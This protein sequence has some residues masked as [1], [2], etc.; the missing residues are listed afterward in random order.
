MHKQTYQFIMFIK[1]GLGVKAV[2]PFNA[3]TKKRKHFAPNNQS[4]ITKGLTAVWDKM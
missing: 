3:F 1:A 2:H 4:C